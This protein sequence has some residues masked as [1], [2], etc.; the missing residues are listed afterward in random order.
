M[1]F[2]FKNQVLKEYFNDVGISHQTSSVKTPQQNRVVERRNQTLVEA[3]RTMLNF[4]CAPLFLWAEAI[5]NACYT[6]TAPS[7]TDDLE[8][9]HMSLL[10]AENQISPFYIVYNQRTRKIMETMNVTFDELS[11]WLLNNLCMMPQALQTPTAS[12]TTA[13]N[14][15]T[16]T[17][18]SSQA[19]DIP[20]TS[21]YVDE[22]QPQQHDQQQDD[23]AQ[24]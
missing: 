9:H 3:A 10:T 24:L 4:S 8:K 23:Q 2:Y 20:N 19:V 13:D 17:N 11:E 22:L 12:T 5:A 14:A 1:E 18:S 21:Q 16:P 15:P 7:F 6:Q